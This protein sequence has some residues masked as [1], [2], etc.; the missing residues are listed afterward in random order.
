MGGY[1]YPHIELKT[2][3]VYMRMYM[4]AFQQGDRLSHHQKSDKPFGVWFH[5]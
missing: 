1:L 3:R 4:E 2:L 5:F